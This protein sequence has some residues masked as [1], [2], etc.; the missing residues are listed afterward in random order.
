MKKI[1]TIIY[2]FLL[3]VPSALATNGSRTGGRTPGTTDLFE[4]PNPLQT[5]SI[6]DLLN[7]I[8]RSLTWVAAP[9]A[10][11]MIIVG[12]FQMMS[13]GGDPEKFKT[14]RKTILYAAVGFAIFLMARL[15][16]GITAELLGAKPE[17]IE[18]IRRITQ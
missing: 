17:T 7:T 15:L 2:T 14:G 5:T 1:V 13:A 4:L 6:I 10:V 9:I 8:I 11:L 12:A 3:T 18:Q 16:I